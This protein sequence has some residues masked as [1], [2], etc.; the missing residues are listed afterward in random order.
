GR[1]VA[2]A[3]VALRRV[4]RWPAPGINGHWISSGA[5]VLIDSR[6]GD[7]QGQTT[8]RTDE[9]DQETDE[10]GEYA[11]EGLA[12]GERVVEVRVAD[13][14]LAPQVR[15]VLVRAGTRHAATDFVLYEGLTL[16]A[17]VVDQQGRPLEG[18][19][20][21]VAEESAQAVTSEDL[22]ATSGADGWF[23]VRGL[24]PG[25]KTLTVFLDGYTTAWRRFETASPP[26][27]IELQPS[28]RLRGEVVDAA[29]GQPIEAFALRLEFE[30]TSMITDA[31]PHPGGLFEDDVPGDVRCQVTVSAPGYEPLT[32][33]DLLPSSTSLAPARFRLLRQP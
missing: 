19:S 1:P 33:T 5:G 3:R 9:A 26:A 16:R 12:E 29:T 27:R 6:G 13:G 30:G 10:R 17:L 23:E 20:V 24:S 7:G 31:Q 4:A 15:T 22:S 8:L 32:L 14:H 18:A 2:G 11:F 25:N 28:L 21:H